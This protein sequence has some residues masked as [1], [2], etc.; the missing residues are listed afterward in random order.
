MAWATSIKGGNCTLRAPAGADN[1]SDLQVFRNRAQVI[2]RWELSAEEI[3][4]ICRTGCIY[5]SV[6]GHTTYPVYVGSET[7][8]RAMSADYGLMPLQSENVKGTDT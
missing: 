4:E 7:E 8:M 1:V 2:S 5:L 6:F 3:E